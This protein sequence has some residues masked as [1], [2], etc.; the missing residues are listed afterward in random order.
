VA[1]TLTVQELDEV[2]FEAFR[3]GLAYQNELTPGAFAACD[4][5]RLFAEQ[6]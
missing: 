3:A 5:C 4:I 6:Y 1:D 2:A